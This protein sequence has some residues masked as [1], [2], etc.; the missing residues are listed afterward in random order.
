MR[1]D[2]IYE[3]QLRPLT[4]SSEFRCVLLFFP[5]GARR[6]PSEAMHVNPVMLSTFHWRRTC[7]NTST[8]RTHIF[9]GSGSGSRTASRPSAQTGYRG[10]RCGHPSPELGGG[11][12]R[13]AL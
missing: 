4:H 9:P 11:A 6:P 3:S 1:G 2:E 12:Y 10:S 7:A 13:A 8:V 5:A